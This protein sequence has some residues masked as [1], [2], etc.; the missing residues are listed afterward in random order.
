MRTA[1][2]LP[3]V[4]R[5][6]VYAPRAQ[7]FGGGPTIEWYLDPLPS[8]GQSRVEFTLGEGEHERREPLPELSERLKALRPHAAKWLFAVIHGG[9]LSVFNV[10]D[11]AELV[12]KWLWSDLQNMKWVEGNFAGHS[13]SYEALA[14]R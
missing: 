10:H 9:V 3:A 14:I 6:T 11:A 13:F 2:T 7:H 5:G 4:L 8:G 1:V 12:Y